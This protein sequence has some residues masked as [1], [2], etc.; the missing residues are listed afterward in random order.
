MP[1]YSIR[2]ISKALSV[3][4]PVV[5]E[6]IHK[7]KKSKLTFKDIENISDDQLFLLIKKNLESENKRYTTLANNFSTYMKELKKTGVNRHLLWE[8]YKQENPDGYGYSQ[9]CFLF[10]KWITA[11]EISMHINHK[12]GDKM[13]V[14]FTGKKLEITNRT[15]GEKQC[16]E[17]F[18]ALLG[19]SQ[20]TYVEASTSQKKADWI[21]LNQNALIYFG[22]VPKAIVP[23]CLKSAVTKCD[24]YEPDINK[25]YCD[26]ARHYETTILPA[27]ALK[28]KDKALVE[29]AVKIVYTQIFAKLRDKIFYSLPELNTAIH[30]LLEMY[31]ARKMQ[32]TGLSRI[33]IFN[34]TEKDMLQPLPTERYVF[35]NHCRLTVPKSYH[36]YLKDDQ[37]YYSVPYHL[38]GCK[39]EIIYSNRVL[40]VY[41]NNMRMCAH[42]RSTKAGGYSTLKEH[43]PEKHKWQDNHDPE[44]IIQRAIQI[45][46]ETEEVIRNILSQQQHP[47]KNYKSCEGV[48][49]LKKM[50]SSQ[51]I[52]EACRR[53]IYFQ[54]Y[55]YKMIKNILNNNMDLVDLEIEIRQTSLPEHSNIRGINYFKNNTNEVLQ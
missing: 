37:H 9:F 33:D 30:E 28:P 26:F 12:A 46:A 51:R 53:A 40:E 11:S 22:G 20:L 19:A 31:N 39:V 1:D 32:R 54:N 48:L 36:I 3:S 8:E 16:V 4:R 35:R 43:M 38:R 49:H 42:S 23:D 55:N 7:I 45:G 10:Q 47:E 6:Y 41:H 29:G 2:K 44:K 25:E 24:R 21:S 34:T 14:D 13:F 5:A 15:T 18:V 50:Y 27:R 52:N 17:I